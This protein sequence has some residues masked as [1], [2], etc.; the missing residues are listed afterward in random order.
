MFFFL[1]HSHF[2][3]IHPSLS[4]G[5]FFFWPQNPRNGVKLL[6]ASVRLIIEFICL[7]IENFYFPHFEDLSSLSLTRSLSVCFDI[8]I[9]DAGTKILY[10]LPTKKVVNSLDLHINVID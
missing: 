1:F 8:L 2:H 10:K 4:F 7:T 6:L 9:E 5:S 3:H